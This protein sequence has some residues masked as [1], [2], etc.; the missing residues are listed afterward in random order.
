MMM[1]KPLTSHRCHELRLILTAAT[2][3]GLGSSFKRCVPGHS[4]GVG[5]YIER[6]HVLYVV[7]ILF[8][9][10]FIPSK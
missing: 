5:T 8:D 1:T 3:E 4:R 10:C 9:E 2:T 6:L 7:A